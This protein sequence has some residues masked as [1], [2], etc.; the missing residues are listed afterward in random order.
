MHSWFDTL[1][2]VYLA[3][4]IHT[5]TSNDICNN[6]AINDSIGFHAVDIG[7]NI[8]FGMKVF[9]KEEELVLSIEA[10]ATN[11]IGFVFSTSMIGDALIYT[12]GKN[13]NK[14]L[15]LYDYHITSKE[16][17]LHINHMIKNIGLFVCH[18]CF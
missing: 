17:S 2:L 10:P 1:K 18:K 8:R 16:L 5:V 12:T 14:P 13:G 6:T 11:W 4:I 7:N 3:L 9:C 15:S